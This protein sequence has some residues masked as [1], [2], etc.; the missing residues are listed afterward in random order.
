MVPESAFQIFAKVSRSTDLACQFSIQIK[1]CLYR[2]FTSMLPNSDFSKKI[3]K[4]SFSIF[5]LFPP[6]YH[7]IS[8]VICIVSPT[9]VL[10]II[11]SL[12][13]FK[14]EL[15]MMTI[16]TSNLFQVFF[17]QFF[18]HLIHLFYFYM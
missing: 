11:F 18:Y 1:H 7:F 16:S 4:F 17:I 12:S 6:F 15:H 8:I 2:Q 3:S 9:F 10:S 5:L 13:E 14:F